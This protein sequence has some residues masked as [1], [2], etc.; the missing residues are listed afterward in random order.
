MATTI[1]F[2]SFPFPAD[3]LDRSERLQRS[4]LFCAF[5]GLKRSEIDGGY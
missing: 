3:L 2:K 4:V 1:F 5:T